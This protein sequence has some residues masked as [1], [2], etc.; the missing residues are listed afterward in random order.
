MGST[1]IIFDVVSP[2]RLDFLKLLVSAGADVDARDGTGETPAITA[3]LLGQY[4]AACFLVGHGADV[5]AK[6][7]LGL[8]LKDWI[9]RSRLGGSSKWR[10]KLILTLQEQGVG[11]S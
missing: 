7:N 1:S 10:E 3:V 8:S 11:V 9:E 2:G 5:F 6:D 4:E